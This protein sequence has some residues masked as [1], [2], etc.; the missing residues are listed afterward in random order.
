MAVDIVVIELACIALGYAVFSIFLQRKL[1]N[2]DRMYEVRD[3]MNAHTKELVEMGKR[4]ESK[5]VIAAKQQELTKLA[6]E[7]MK[8]QMKPM[9]VLLPITIIL[10]YVLLPMGFPNQNATV[11]IF[12]LQLSYK[13]FF[14]ASIFIIGIVLSVSMQIYDKRRLRIK[15]Q[16]STVD[17]AL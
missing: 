16:N 10:Y 13:T 6:T 12:S 4:Q 5:E 2:I 1:S 15:K 11:T 9:F 3:R 8:S 14:I 7:S 17:P